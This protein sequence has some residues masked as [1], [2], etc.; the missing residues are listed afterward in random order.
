MLSFLLSSS[1]W[2][3]QEQCSHM[4]HV[5]LVFTGITFDN[6]LKFRT[7]KW[8]WYNYTI[9][10]NHFHDMSTLKTQM[11]ANQPWK[12]IHPLVQIF[13]MICLVLIQLNNSWNERVAIIIQSI[14]QFLEIIS[15]ICNRHKLMI[16]TMM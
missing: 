2:S 9:L 4:L 10:Y 15:K 13:H 14:L 7:C 16:E 3:C 8:K 1:C 11:L 5:T 12:D 6:L